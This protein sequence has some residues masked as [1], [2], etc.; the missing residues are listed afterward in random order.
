MTVNVQKKIYMGVWR[1]MLPVPK[2]LSAIGIKKN[3]SGA[4]TKAALL[5]KEERRVHHF[6]VKEMAVAEEPITMKF[7][8]ER[9]NLPLGRVA[10]I[11]N[12]L[13]TMKA[14]VYRN[15]SDGINW[16]YPFSLEDTG[17]E[18]TASTG[19]RFFAA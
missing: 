18:M 13:E 10:D 3:V 8:G 19:E 2:A 11:V 16:A 14:F 1:L 4:K 17:H 15:N 5:S 6:A 9:L 12:K 7:I